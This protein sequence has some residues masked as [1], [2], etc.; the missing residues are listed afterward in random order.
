M[1][2]LYD[3]RWQQ[4]R[5]RFL[6]QHRL[7]EMCGQRG[8]VVASNVIDHRIAHKSD[9]TL[10]RSESNWAA[11]CKPCHDS[12]KAMLE[13]GDKVPPHTSWNAGGGPMEKPMNDPPRPTWTNRTQYP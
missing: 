9:P 6:R 13:R 11:L 10:F 7:C 5:L 12:R 8:L 3:Y 1:S 2:G 4:A